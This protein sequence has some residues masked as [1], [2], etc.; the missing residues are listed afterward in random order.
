M[1]VSRV[2]NALTSECSGLTI[3]LRLPVRSS[4]SRF[5]TTMPISMISLC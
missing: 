1:P 2:Q 5:S 3:T 4:V